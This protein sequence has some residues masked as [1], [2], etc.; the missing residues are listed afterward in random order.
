MLTKLSWAALFFLLFNAKVAQAQT[1]GRHVSKL[2]VT[3]YNLI[4]KDAV[5]K[6]VADVRIADCIAF[7]TVESS[8]SKRISVFNINADHY[9]LEDGQIL[10]SVPVGQIRKYL[11]RKDSVKL[12]VSAIS[13]TGATAFKKSTVITTEDLIKIPVF[14]L[15]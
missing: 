7:I 11:K 10:F 9:F 13:M 12:T 4:S 8:N 15:E 2:Y 14:E 1:V 3:H 6:F 5:V